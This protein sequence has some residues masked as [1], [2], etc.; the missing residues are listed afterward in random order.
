MPCKWRV[1]ISLSG[2]IISIAVWKPRTVFSST[3]MI[4][5]IQ[6]CCCFISLGSKVRRCEAEFP[7]DLQCLRNKLL[8]FGGCLLLQH[9]P[10]YPDWCTGSFSYS[11]KWMRTHYVPDTVFGTHDIA[12][13]WTSPCLHGTYILMEEP[14]EIKFSNFPA[15]KGRDIL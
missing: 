13:N 2:Q 4:S 9:N 8:R 1:H 7:A 14:T 5:N 15:Q 10:A 11:F 12:I 6:D 3:Q